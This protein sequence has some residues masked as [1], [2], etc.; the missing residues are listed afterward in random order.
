MG[1]NF[2]TIDPLSLL[3]HNFDLDFYVFMNPNSTE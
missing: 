1:K 3:V 2:F